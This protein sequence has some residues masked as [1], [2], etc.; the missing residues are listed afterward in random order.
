MNSLDWSHADELIKEHSPNPSLLLSTIYIVKYGYFHL[1]I[2][3]PP[4]SQRVV[5][6]KKI[7]TPVEEIKRH[8]N[9]KEEKTY[10]YWFSFSLLFWYF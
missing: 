6:L 10:L 9:F 7:F 4:Y 3:P 2:F 1:N 8:N 5:D